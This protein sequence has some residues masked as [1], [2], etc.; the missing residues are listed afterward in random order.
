TLDWSE[1]FGLWAGL[2]GGAF[3]ALGSHGVDQLSVQRYLSARGLP[4]ARRAVWMSGL[5]AM[6][7]F[8][9]FLLIG[10]GLWSFY[11]LN[12][13]AVPF[14][15]A[16]RIFARFIL[17]ELPTGLVGLLLGA[18]F[19]AA[20]T[21]SLNSCATVAVNDLLRV[22]P[23]RQLRVTRILTAVFG[24]IQIAV[25]IAGQW[26]Q[27]SIVSSVLGIAAFTTGIVLG[28]FFLGMFTRRVG[29]H[30]ALAGLAV[31][32]AGMTWIFFATPLAWTWYAL[33]GSLLTVAAGLAASWIL[34]DRPENCR[35][36]P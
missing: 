16:D 30:A 17:D 2:V 8:A 1:P 7:Q 24:A 31:G 34:P 6:A 19:A 11:Q 36:V 29:Q 32:L 14:E 10:V 12:P 13:P 25:G 3:I 23:E 4:E 27:T 15:R 33:A 9:L 18:I 20:M 21:S 35:A 28:V 5:V 26:V 22:S